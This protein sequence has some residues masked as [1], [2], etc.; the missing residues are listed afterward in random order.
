MLFNKQKIV[1]TALSI[2]F[3]AALIGSISSTIAWYQYSTRATAIYLGTSAGGKGNLKLR[4][5]GSS[6]SSW[7]SDLTYRQNAN[8]SSNLGKQSYRI[9]PRKRAVAWRNS[10]LGRLPDGSAIGICRNHE[11]SPHY[12][13]RMH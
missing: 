2:G 7:T 4:I 6:N 5:K 3:G 11:S 1:V 13:H 9:V 10:Y 12:H 8:L